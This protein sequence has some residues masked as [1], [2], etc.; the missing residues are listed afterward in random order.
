MNAD[1]AVYL[2][3]SALIKLVVAEA[4]SEALTSYL[5]GRPNRVSCTLARVEI[6]RAA[7]LHGDAAIRRAR[8]LLE[9]ISLVR[10]D[11]L[12]LD[13]A[14]DLGGETLRSLDAIHL[15]AARAVGPSLGEVITYDH[16]MAN[17]AKSID[18]VVSAPS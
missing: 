14:A 2:D 13:E 11:D 16:R 1:A 5:R 12:L 6:V 9:R 10:L 18:F 7:R 17:A 15:A 3:S 4:E 8:E